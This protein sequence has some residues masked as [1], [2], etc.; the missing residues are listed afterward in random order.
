[1]R[2]IFLD[3]FFSGVQDN[4]VAI[5]DHPSLLSSLMNSQRINSQQNNLRQ[6]N[7]RQ[8]NLRQNNLQQKFDWK[9]VGSDDEGGLR[10]PFHPP[11]RD[12]HGSLRPLVRDNYKSLRPLVRDNYESLRHSLRSYSLPNEDE[13][14]EE[15]EYFIMDV[16]D[17]P[18]NDENQLMWGENLSVEEE[19]QS[20][21]NGENT[22]NSE[23]KSAT[24][25]ENKSMGSTRVSE[26]KSMESNNKS[27]GGTRGSEKSM[28]SDNKSMGGARGG[29]DPPS[30]MG[31]ILQRF[32]QHLIKQG[33]QLVCFDFD[34]TIVNTM[35]TPEFRTP[36]NICKRIS[37]LFIKL[38]KMLLDNG[39]AVSIVTFNV[40]PNIGPAV[41]NLLGTKIN[42]FARNDSEI[43]T[44]KSWH[45]D[46]AIRAYNKSMEKD[47]RTG[48][49]P[50]NVLFLD[51]DFENIKIATRAGYNCI[52]N[53]AVIS[54]D[55]IV[56]YIELF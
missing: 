53:P 25:S 50:Q 24:K 22:R 49:R 46:S 18:I 2:N 5:S 9:S 13:D 27:M 8:N 35:Y 19:N 56:H 12:N 44:G 42:V 32:V 34:Q 39:I 41:S 28:E 43:G 21:T 7:L 48:L 26:N 10:P 31:E 40:N 29:E 16:E 33:I 11:V 36:E 38:G 6:N 55:D 17:K 14:E 54:L 4:D 45:L 23:N 20:M 3:K 47:D 52:P 1:M 15:E 37:P 51:D 30:L